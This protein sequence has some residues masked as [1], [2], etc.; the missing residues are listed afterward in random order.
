MN[1][2]L[3]NVHNLEIL[4]EK[5]A[6]LIKELQE[7][8][9]VKDRTYREK[10]DQKNL[11]NSM[12]FYNLKQKMIGDVESAQRSV[13]Q[14]NLE[15]MEVASKLTLLQNHQLL[16]EMEFQTQ[17]CEDLMKKNDLLEKQIFEI[18]HYV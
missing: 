16:V 14:L 17:Q 8:I 10:I 18:Q 9:A 2:K 3:E 1:Q 15:H 4:T 12:R 6:I 7:S 13:D 5:Q 11:K